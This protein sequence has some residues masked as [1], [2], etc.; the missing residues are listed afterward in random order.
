MKKI[1]LSC[2]IAICLAVPVGCSSTY[3]VRAKDG[4]EFV[5]KGKPEYNKKYQSYEFKDINGNKWI[6]N[7]EEIKSMEK[8]R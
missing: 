2:I 4:R 3:T 7:R 1:F 6:I 8:N 5:A